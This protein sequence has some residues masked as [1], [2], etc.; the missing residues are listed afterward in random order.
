MKYYLTY[1]PSVQPI[2]T[3]MAVTDNKIKT[4]AITAKKVISNDRLARSM[5]TN[6]APIAIAAEV[7]ADFN[8]CPF[9]SYHQKSWEEKNTIINVSNKNK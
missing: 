6:A 7:Y 9:V 1:N 8:I 5:T 3:K 4:N 2:P